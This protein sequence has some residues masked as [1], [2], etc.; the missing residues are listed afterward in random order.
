MEPHFMAAPFTPVGMISASP[1][2]ANLLDVDKF[3]PTDV[4]ATTDLIM[5]LDFLAMQNIGEDERLLR[6]GAVIIT[7]TMSNNDVLPDFDIIFNAYEAYGNPVPTAPLFYE[8]W[9]RNIHVTPLASQNNT[10]SYG[11]FFGKRFRTGSF[12][13][14]TQSW[15]NASTVTK[16]YGE[17][18]IVG[19]QGGGS[20]AAQGAPMAG[21]LILQGIAGISQDVKISILL[22][23]ETTYDDQVELFSA[24]F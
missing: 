21:A 15:S 19:T 5:P 7:H 2:V 13:A 16:G 12:N 22:A 9:R 4:T 10:V 23:S 3:G 20:A 8:D 14:V 18:F 17:P 24:A 6:I 1:V 11:I